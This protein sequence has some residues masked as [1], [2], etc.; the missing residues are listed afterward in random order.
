MRT[1]SGALAN[2]GYR[3][4]VFEDGHMAVRAHTASGSHASMA[5]DA[6]LRTAGD[7]VFRQ[8]VPVEDAASNTGT[9]HYLMGSKWNDPLVTSQGLTEAQ[10]GGVRAV[11]AS[12]A[13]AR[14]GRYVNIREWE[15]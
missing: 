5:G 3:F 15:N 10:A 8:G 2:G 14:H 13:F 4:V 1:P 6:P 12:N 7:I 9:G 11:E